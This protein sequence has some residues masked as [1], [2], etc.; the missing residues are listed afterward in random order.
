MIKD[1]PPHSHFRFLLFI[2]ILFAF[3]VN[4]NISACSGNRRPSG[5]EETLK[6]S[7]DRVKEAFIETI[8]DVGG[9]INPR[10]STETLLKG[11]VENYHYEFK[12]IPSGKLSSRICF[13]VKGKNGDES[14]ALESLVIKILRNKLLVKEDKGR[15]RASLTP[16]MIR[17]E[18]ATVCLYGSSTT[19]TFQSSGIVISGDGL[20]LTTAHE[21][22][23]SKTIFVKWSDKKVFRGK[24]RFISP[25]YDLALV[26]TGVSSPSFI[27]L[28][29]PKSIN[30]P[31][32]KRIYTFGCPYG[33][34]GTLAQGRI[35][36]APRIVGSILLYQCDLP[37]Y[38]GN[39]GGPVFDN[40]GNLIGLVKGRLKDTDDI[41]FI[42]PSFYLSVFLKENNDRVAVSKKMISVNQDRD[43][44][45]WFGLGLAAGSNIEKESAFRRVLALRPDFTPA[46]YHLGLVLNSEGKVR[47]ELDIWKR[48]VK[49]MP[50]WSEAWY[51]LGNASFKSGNLRTAEKAY[52]RAISLSPEDPRY[53]NN[54]GEIYRRE[55]KYKKAEIYF[56]KALSLYPGYAVAH[57]NLGILFD[58]ALD[59]PEL[60]VYHYKEYLKLSPDAPDRE[61]VR[62]WIKEAEKRF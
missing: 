22:S 5:K 48:L 26:E 41:S 37:V 16:L 17:Y 49:L 58:Q 28:N 21:I 2:F 56:K 12:I 29:F 7:H 15:K 4:I 11:T 57:Y 53:Y 24:I 31:I 30:V 61:K 18:R 54:L 19:E 20:I 33:L 23:N 46:L 14:K 55:G 60:A 59:K 52:K 51:R 1:K 9:K 44:A 47:E 45:Y 50:G 43:W 13:K 25:L 40:E 42:I 36:A 3:A 38:P 10:E 8:R 27:P 62:R 39:S 35:A 6:V 32:G 34:L